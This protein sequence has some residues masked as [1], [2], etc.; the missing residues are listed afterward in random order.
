M[1]GKT[2]AA[3]ILERLGIADETIEIC[4]QVAVSAGIRGRQIVLAPAD[5]LRATGATTAAIA[6]DTL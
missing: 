4:D 5:Y 3:R 2:N 6:R 1:V